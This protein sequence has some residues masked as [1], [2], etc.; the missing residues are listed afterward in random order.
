[1]IS[2]QGV[3]SIQVAHLMVSI[4]G[5]EQKHLIV[6]TCPVKPNR[7]ACHSIAEELQLDFPESIISVLLADIPGAADMLHRRTP[8]RIK[9]G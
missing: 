1:M 6:N 4:D 2:V 7:A 8:S 3:N 9:L 5:V